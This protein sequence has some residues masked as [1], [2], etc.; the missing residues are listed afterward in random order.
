MYLTIGSGDITAFLS[1][2][3]TK[4]F[5]VLLQKFVADNSPNYNSFASPIDALRTGAILEKRYAMQVDVDYYSQ[6][7]AICQDYNCLISSIDFAKINLGVIVDFDELKTIHLADYLDITIPLSELSQ[8]EYT[9]VIKKKFKSN[10][11]QLQFQLL[12]S[13]LKSANLVFLSVTS[14]DDELNNRR[15][16]FKNDYLK[17][18]I[19]RDESVI[20]QIKDKA[21]FFQRIKDYFGKININ[22]IE[23][24][25]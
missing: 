20:K 23:V 18:R 16:I 15:I 17:F 5:S 24:K 7:K 19:K 9:E 2:K 1:G 6:Y 8:K 25:L 10:Y 21:V 13:G 3:N 14:Y 12:C 4:G 22:D 11:N